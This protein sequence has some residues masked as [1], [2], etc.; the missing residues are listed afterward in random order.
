MDNHKTKQVMKVE[1][2]GMKVVVLHNETWDYEFRVAEVRKGKTYWVDE[3][4]SFGEAA[5][6][7]IAHLYD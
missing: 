2:F 3:F 6:Q 7:A 5:E 4:D 1:M